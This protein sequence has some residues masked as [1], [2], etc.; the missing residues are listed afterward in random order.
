MDSG[1]K[2]RGS[3]GWACGLAGPPRPHSW[4]Q[5]LAGSLLYH[6]KAPP[7]CLYGRV[8]QAPGAEADY[9]KILSGCGVAEAGD[10]GDSRGRVG[11]FF[12]QPL[13][14]PHSPEHWLMLS[15]VSTWPAPCWSS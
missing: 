12:Q 13:L 3:E 10:G 9:S 14:L 1:E 8:C 15:W 6:I 5:S 11:G 4:L 2:V 7:G